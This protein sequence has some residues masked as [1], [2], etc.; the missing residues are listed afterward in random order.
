MRYLALGD[1]ISIDYWT[2]VEGGGAASQFARRVGSSGAEFVNR[3]RDGNMTEGVLMDLELLPF[4]P[5][6]VTLT[7]GGNDLALAG[8]PASLILPAIARI[9]EEVAFYN[10]NARERMTI[11]STFSHLVSLVPACDMC[12]RGHR[13][14]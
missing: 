11:E 3:T 8:R 5:E 13:L 10:G 1:S 4:R 12:R 14:V 7:V 6:I 9:T 2:G